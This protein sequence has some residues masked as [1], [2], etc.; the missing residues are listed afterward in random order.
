M[1]TF[2]FIRSQKAQNHKK[3]LSDMDIIIYI[4]IIICYSFLVSS[5]VEFGVSVMLCVAFVNCWC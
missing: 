1:M 5:V 2:L 3:N 4:I